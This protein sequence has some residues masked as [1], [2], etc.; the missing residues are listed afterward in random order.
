MNLSELSKAT[1]KSETAIRSVVERLVER[2][3]V[4]GHGIT[5]GR[6]YTLSSSVYRKVGLD[7]EYVRQVGFD[8]IQQEEMALRYAREHGSIS[9][10]E[11]AELCRL[12]EDQASLLLRG[13]ASI[14]KLTLVGKGRSA[15]YIT[16]NRE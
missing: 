13:L 4:D 7:S 11:V 15:H 9:R 5:R 14:G 2:G 3:F 8:R 1:Q 16:A 10:K 12:G 6:I